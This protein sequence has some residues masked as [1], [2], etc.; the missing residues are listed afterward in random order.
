MFPGFYSERFSFE[1]YNI[2][3]RTYAHQYYHTVIVT[4]IV[5][6]RDASTFSQQLHL[7]I[8]TR[9]SMNN[10]T[11]V[12]H[13]LGQGTIALLI[14]ND[15]GNESSDI[16]FQETDLPDLNA[17]QY[18][19]AV[20]QLEDKVYQDVNSPPSVCVLTKKV[21]KLVSRRLFDLTNSTP[22]SPRVRVFL[23]IKFDPNGCSRRIVSRELIPTV[24]STIVPRE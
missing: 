1:G 13:S 23:S 20:W 15:A 7:L 19:G 8:P 14:T 3:I 21:T 11:S 6:E 18:L 22:F 9:R 2:E 5:V 4:Q 24:V 12:E 17:T 16:D 10:P